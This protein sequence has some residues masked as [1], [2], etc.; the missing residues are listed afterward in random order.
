MAIR[1]N[2]GEPKMF[3]Q[4][5]ALLKNCTNVTVILAS[6][7]DNTLSVTVLPKSKD[8]GDNAAAL[9]TP[10]SLTATA[11]ELDA[12]FVNVLGGYVNKHQSLAEQLENTNAILEAAKTESQKKATTAISKA[13]KPTEKAK[14]A[15]AESSDDLEDTEDESGGD[16]NATGGDATS[17]TDSSKTEVAPAQAGDDLW[18]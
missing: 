11:A 2:Y 8:T 10:L 15:K 3:T 5:E 18:S 12:E 4:L 13:A 14:P 16:E 6:N 1:K 17:A 7:K 9:S